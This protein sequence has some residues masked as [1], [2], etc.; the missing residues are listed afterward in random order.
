MTRSRL[1]TYALLLALHAVAG[2]GKHADPVKPGCVVDADCGG[3]RVCREQLC[4]VVDDA[5]RRLGFNL[6]PS[7]GSPYPPQTVPVAGVRLDEPLTIGIDPG[8][9]VSGAIQI[10][11]GSGDANGQLKFKQRALKNAFV[12]ETR[13][14]MNRYEVF[15]LPGRYDVT[16]FPDNASLPT[17][18]WRDIALELDSDPK[19]QMNTRTVEIGGT[20]S[21]TDSATAESSRVRGA[22]VFAVSRDTGSVSST[23]V[24][25]EA[26]DFTIHVLEDSGLY[27]LHVAPAEPNRFDPEQVPNYVPEASFE[28]AFRVDGAQWENLLYPEAASLGLSLGE[29]GYAPIEFQF[30]LSADTDMDIDWT[31]S[32]VSLETEAGR[33]KLTIRHRVDSSGRFTLPL[34]LGTYAVEV[35]TPPG[36]PVASAR[37]EALTFSAT[38]PTVTFDLGLR[39]L[40]EG[41]VQ[42]HDGTFVAGAQLSAVP[43]SGGRL[44]EPLNVPTDER[45]FFHLWLDDVPYRI[46]ISPADPTLPRGVVDWEPGSASLETIRLAEPALTWGKVLGTPTNGDASEDWR[47]LPD[48]VIRAF[49][50][51]AAGEPIVLGE[52]KTDAQGAFR[53]VLPARE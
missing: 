47:E 23:A 38:S 32:S 4:V 48:V 16:F 6:I 21:R 39:E 29:Y 41:A 11:G 7:G 46:T 50:E 25:N 15:V 27:D 14:D 52:S 18:V 42:S 8:V 3:E 20:L 43:L 30:R 1:R 40:V 2:C 45:G 22:L 10:L 37:I 34:I 17:R 31:G 53:I 28:S 33:G 5:P 13:V 36:L 49:E 26:G 51:S 44:A 19:F 9:K 35:R 24:T 12:R